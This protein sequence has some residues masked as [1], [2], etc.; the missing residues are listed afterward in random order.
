MKLD[1][2]NAINPLFASSSAEVPAAAA[3]EMLARQRIFIFLLSFGAGALIVNR[4]WVRG[5][6]S[7][8]LVL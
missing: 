1:R 5:S 7:K 3:R 8:T 6:T 2:E 4:I